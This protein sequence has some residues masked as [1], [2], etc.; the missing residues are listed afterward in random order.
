MSLK[1][2]SE[3]FFGPEAIGQDR[4][5]QQERT[6]VDIYESFQDGIEP[7]PALLLDESGPKPKRFPPAFILQE[8]IEGPYP[9]FRSLDLRV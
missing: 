6:I 8:S 2:M 3:P 4:S 1:P 9:L 7:F 5:D